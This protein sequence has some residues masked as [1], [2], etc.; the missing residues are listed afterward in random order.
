MFGNCSRLEEETPDFGDLTW[1]DLLPVFAEIANAEYEA[2]KPALQPG[3][4]VAMEEIVNDSDLGAVCRYIG[5][6]IIEEL[7]Y[8]ANPESDLAR[9]RSETAATQWLNRAAPDTGALTAEDLTAHFKAEALKM[10]A[11]IRNDYYGRITHRAIVQRVLAESDIQDMARLLG[12][13]QVAEI[14][15]Q[16]GKGPAPSMLRAPVT[17]TI[18]DITVGKSSDVL[19]PNFYYPE[20]ARRANAERERAARVNSQCLN[21]IYNAPYVVRRPIKDD[22]LFTPEQMRALT[23]FPDRPWLDV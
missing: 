6:E 17:G 9:L 23:F 13:R 4:K 14:A 5:S 16:L 8:R 10:D 15:F 22:S 1:H 19:L 18:E 7:K 20:E 3:F 11:R 21:D 2:L 12:H